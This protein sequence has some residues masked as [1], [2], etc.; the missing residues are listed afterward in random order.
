[1]ND[2]QIDDLKQYFAATISQT[3]ANLDN[4]I[5]GLDNKIESLRQDMMDGFA[6]VAEVIEELQNHYDENIKIVDQRLTKLESKAA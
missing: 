1:M 2:D 5:A 6:G 3:E 4:K